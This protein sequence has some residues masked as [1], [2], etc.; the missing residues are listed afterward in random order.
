MAANPKKASKLRKKKSMAVK[1][2]RSKA[3]LP[4]PPGF[5]TVTSYLVVRNAGHAIDFYKRAFGAK[6]RFRMLAPDS[7]TGHAEVEIGT[8][9][10]MLGDEFPE[11][12][13]LAPAAGTK[14]P[15]SFYL[16]VPDCDQV[17]QEAT[18]AG[19]T[20]VAAL[21]DMF[22]GDRFGT[23]QDPFGHVWSIATHK[24]DVSPAEMAK[25]AQEQM[26]QQPQTGGV[27]PG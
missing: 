26:K 5:H 20:V 2:V 7:R 17:F 6:E 16:Y 11:R 12:G 13:S 21:Q 22:W 15:V 1:P 27:P 4:I 24:R 18:R 3:V 9:I 23:V 8:S 19:A 10:I 14:P 25:A